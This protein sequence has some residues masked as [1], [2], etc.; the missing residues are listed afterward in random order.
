[1]YIWNERFW[2]SDKKG[3]L[4]QGKA[5]KE[6]ILAK[7]YKPYEEVVS[8]AKKNFRTTTKTSQ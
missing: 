1:M 6:S 3:Y 7:E 8:K 4:L 5:A 2:S